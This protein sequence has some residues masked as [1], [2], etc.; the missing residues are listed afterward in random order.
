[1]GTSFLYNF[2]KIKSYQMSTQKKVPVDKVYRL[3]NGSPLSYTLASRNN[4]RYPLMW[5]DEESNTTPYVTTLINYVE[6][7]F[8]SHHVQSFSS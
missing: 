5:Y 7:T 6:N 3:I 8:R 4:P 1:M 2:V